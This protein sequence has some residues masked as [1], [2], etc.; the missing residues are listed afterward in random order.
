MLKKRKKVKVV[1]INSGNANACT[2]AQGVQAVKITQRIAA[3]LF[4][5]LPD[6]VLLASTGVIGVQLDMKK[7]RSGL[8]KASSQLNAKNFKDA[9]KAILTTDRFPKIYNKQTK[10][11]KLF[12]FAKG[13]GMV[14]PNMATMLCYLMTDLK[15]P[16]S[17]LQRALRE[18][19]NISFNNIS[20]D[21][22]IS[23]NDM[24]VLLSN[25]QS[26][27][28]V[29]SRNDSI[30][31]EFKTVLLDACWKLAK[32]MVR[33]G[34]G[35]QKIILV[36]VKGAKTGSDARKVARSVAS[37]TLF[38]CAVF[39]RDPNW[40][41]AAARVGCTSVKIKPEKLDVALFNTFVYKNGQPVRF[42]PK[43]LHK[44]MKKNDE[45]KV[46]INLKLGKESGIAYG[47]DLS[48]DYVKLNSAYFT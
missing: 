6:E 21:G 47:C 29:K 48:Y 30:Y 28:E 11:F 13:A 9:A 14:H 12:G 4:Q 39:G 15:M 43:I 2:G 19:V 45:I 36:N 5:V 8:E 26:N 27:V 31:K 34:E 1:V 16:Q 23:T 33:D 24:V 20:V 22:D 17:L 44:Q 37:S 46:N 25:S 42:N 7:M 18:A 41:R 10:S 40:G 38:K 32:D 3:K 35:S